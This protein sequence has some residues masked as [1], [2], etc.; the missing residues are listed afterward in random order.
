MLSVI[1]S[2]KH[3][4]RPQISSAPGREAAELRRG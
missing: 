1:T 3:A 4:R 2:L